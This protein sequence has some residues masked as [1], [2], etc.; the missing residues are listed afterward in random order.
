MKAKSGN[1]VYLERIL[2]GKVQNQVPPLS[3]GIGSIKHL[4]R[5]PTRQRN[6]DQ[7]TESHRGG[8]QR[9]GAARLLQ[10]WRQGRGSKAYRNLPALLREIRL[11]VFQCHQGT[12]SAKTAEEIS[13]GTEPRPSSGTVRDV[14]RWGAAG[15]ES[16]LFSFPTDQKFSPT[17]PFNFPVILLPSWIFHVPLPQ[18]HISPSGDL[19]YSNTHNV[20]SPVLL[21]TQVHSD[22][23]SG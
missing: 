22:P 5:E 10:G 2:L 4:G 9:S 3:S 6:G 19:A 18:V 14:N 17:G 7:E 13:Q 11:H 21:P 20:L 16:L 8:P 23:P 1:E 12:L 15:V